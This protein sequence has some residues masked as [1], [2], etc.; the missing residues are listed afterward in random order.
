MKE[1]SWK[2][3]KLTA[4]IDKEASMLKPQEVCFRREGCSYELINLGMRT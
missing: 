1:K 4:V 3:G 2:V